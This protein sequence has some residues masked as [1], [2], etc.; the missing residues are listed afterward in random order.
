MW[1][2]IEPQ[3]PLL[4]GE[5]RA[6][7]QFLVSQTYIP[8]RVLRGAWAE[9]LA[10]TGREEEIPEIVNRARIGNFFPAPEWDGLRYVLPLP[11]SAASCKLEEG[12]A[13]EPLLDHRG[14]GVVD[15]LLP[16]LAYR[17]LQEQGA[18]FPVPF[19][20]NCQRCGAP[21]EA[22]GGFYA[23]YGEREN[24][25]V[26]SRPQFHGQ[27]KVAL[28]RYRR[29]SAEG[30]LY[31]AS[32]LS[33]RTL[34]PD[35]KQEETALVFVGRVHVS[36]L[37]ALD[38]LLK[39]LDRVALGAL[40]TRGY[41]RVRVQEADVHLLSLEERL[42]AFNGLLKALWQDIRQ[43]A[44]NA[45]DLPQEPQ[46]LY[47]SVDLL[48]PGVFQERGLPVLTPTLTIGGRTLKPVFWMTRPDMASGWS[49]AW[50]L[51]KMTHL[52]AKMGSVYVYRWD[53]PPEDLLPA[54]QALEEQGVGERRDE[55]F[56]ECLVCHPFHLEVE[57]K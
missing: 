55:G 8:G 54:L 46:D 57:E 19:L 24:R 26:L 25:F 17:L 52:A 21:M 44:E 56:G 5:A 12:F 6:D 48:A 1:L 37:E 40:H 31:T 2:K 39:A 9:W 20:L 47:F 41:G 36:D 22:F 18:R 28:S 11:L 34:R 23:V 16:H 4:L 45:Q 50:G 35:S 3:E 38:S 43:V 42:K 14:H 13:S 30:M 27:T 32:A 53:G 15:T 10:R 51:P 29:A 7:S 33:P 49:V